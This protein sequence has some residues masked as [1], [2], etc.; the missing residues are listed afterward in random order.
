M[1][2]VNTIAIGAGAI[3]LF[4]S[5]ATYADMAN[6]SYSVDVGGYGPLWDLS[7]EYSTEIGDMGSF[8]FDLALAPSGKIT[9]GGDFALEGRLLGAYFDLNGEIADSDVVTG[10]S[11][12]P[13][14]ALELSVSG[15]GTVEEAGV[16]INVPSFT[17]TAKLALSVDSADGMLVGKGSATVKVTVQY[18]NPATGRLVT[19]TVSATEPIPEGYIVLPVDVTGDWNLTLNLTPS[20]TK[21]AGT[22]TIVTSCGTTVE[23]TATGSYSSKTDTSNISLKGTGS[24]AGTSLVLVISTAGSAMDIH[25]VTGKLFGQSL[26]IKVR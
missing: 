8:D 16:D 26:N 22:A 4:T 5:R 21:Y 2:I 9:G 24:A 25:S 17:E 6:G 14:V 7:G 15:S 1:K 23:F 18:V 10:S 12:S 13:K 20:G 3:L 19:K 11:T